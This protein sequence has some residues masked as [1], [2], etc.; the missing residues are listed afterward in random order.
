M[1]SYFV[2]KTETGQITQTGNCDESEIGLYG[3]DQGFA[4]GVGNVDI[5]LNYFDIK[6]SKLLII[7]PKPD[8]SLW[9]IFDFKSKFWVVNIERADEIQRQ[10]RNVLL[11]QTD[12][13]Q[14]PDVPL[15]T[16]ESWAIYRQ[17]LRDITDQ[18]GY[19]LEVIWPDPPQ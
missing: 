2:Y 4:V 7:P 16:K 15:A 1:I 8:E 17:A 9:W 6:N 19:P 13:T 3:T 5:D 14:L 10:K 18:P 11:T 12:W